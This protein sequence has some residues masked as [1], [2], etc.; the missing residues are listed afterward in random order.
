SELSVSPDK[1]LQVPYGV[2]A[3]LAQSRAWDGQPAASTARVYLHPLPHS[4]S[5]FRLETPDP[6][7]AAPDSRLRAG[8]SLRLDDRRR[9]LVNRQA[10]PQV[11]KQQGDW[12][13]DQ[14]CDRNH[15][16]YYPDRAVNDRRSNVDG[17]AHCLF[18]VIAESGLAGR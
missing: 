10:P 4:S 17:I 18:E 1:K 3:P 16:S 6:R 5:V 15:Y 12:Q 14:D 2:K 11:A 9:S 13:Q 8:D 7:L